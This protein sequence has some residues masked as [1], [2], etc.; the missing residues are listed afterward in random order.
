[1]IANKRMILPG[2]TIFGALMCLLPFGVLAQNYTPRELENLRRGTPNDA[3]LSRYRPLPSEPVLIRHAT[4]MTAAGPELNNSDIL[5][6]EGKIA[7]LGRDLEAPPGAVEIDGSG[8][9]VTPGLIDSH[10]HIGVSATPEVAAHFDNNDVG[11][12]TPQLWIDHGIWPQGPGFSRALAGGVTSALLLP[13]SGDL[14]EG[15]GVPVKMVPA[16]TPQEMIFPGAPQSLKMACGENPKR[17]PGFPDTRMGNVFGYRQ[18]FQ[19]ALKY[20]REWDEWLAHPEGD[21]PARDFGKETLAEALR[22]NIL[23]QVH[24]YRAD[25]ITS[26]LELAQEFGLEIRSIHHGI[27]AYKVRDYLARHGTAASVWSDHWGFKMEAFDGILQNAALLTEAG[28]RTVIHSDSD[29]GIQILN[30]DAAKALYGGIQVG[31]NINR[32]D[33]LRWITANPAWV[34]GVEDRVGTLEEGKNADVVL[35]SG[36]PFSVYSRTERV[37]IDG[38]LVYDRSNPEFQPLSDFELGNRVHGGGQ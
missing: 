22:G 1:M 25:D 24:C 6:Q 3:W 28:V 32:N 5:L 15:R 34:L 21:P 23:I 19:G 17:G 16:R 37:W 20:R 18:A 29:L 35:W 14:I 13:G 10:S 2:S 7:A 31:I 27:E 26:I 9:F 4:L 11:M 8:T 33:A 38:A 12:T 36:D 30:Q